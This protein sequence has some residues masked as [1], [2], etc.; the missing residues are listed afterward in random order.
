[1]D[2]APVFRFHLVK[3]DGIL[4]LEVD[5][6]AKIQQQCATLHDSR[7]EPE[8]D[9]QAQAFILLKALNGTGHNTQQLDEREA[10]AVIGMLDEEQYD[11]TLYTVIL[12]YS[13]Q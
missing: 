13:A 7:I 5:H 10:S 11:V 8:L 3:K 2:C 6:L 1:M 9:I 12:T 4:F